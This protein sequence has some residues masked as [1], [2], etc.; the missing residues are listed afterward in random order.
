MVGVG[1]GR[2]VLGLD[3]VE[4]AHGRDHVVGPA[5]GGV[6]VRT[7]AGG[8]QQPAREVPQGLLGPGVGAPVDARKPRDLVVDETQHEFAQGNDGGSRLGGVARAREPLGGIA[9]D[10]ASVLGGL[11][12]F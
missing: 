8:V 11:Q 10:L 1:G 12:L 5:R 7:D 3:A 2:C 9:H 6:F 4:H